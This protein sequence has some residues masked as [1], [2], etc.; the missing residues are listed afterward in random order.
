VQWSALALLVATVFLSGC[1]KDDPSNDINLMT[2]MFP[3]GTKIVAELARTDFEVT[4]GLMFRTSLPVDRGMLFV[5]PKPDKYTYWTYQTKIPLDMVWMTQDHKIVEIVA[6]AQPCTTKASECPKL[7]GHEIAALVL[8][9]NAGVAAK[10]NL[11]AGD[12]LDF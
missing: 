1:N 8:E 3:N 11:H 12:Y 5:H 4:R 6:N 9:V 10:N 7:G 2:V